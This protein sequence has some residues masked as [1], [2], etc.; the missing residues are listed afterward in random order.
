MSAFVAFRSIFSR[1]RSEYGEILSISLY[2]ARMRKN[3]DQTNPKYGQFFP[4]NSAYPACR[5]GLLVLLRLAY[6]IG[7]LL[8]I[9]TDH[10]SREKRKVLGMI[11]AIEARLFILLDKG[12]EQ[13]A[14]VSNLSQI[15]FCDLLIG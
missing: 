10:D 3:A 1:I 2:L 14:D 4:L 5:K 9:F 13:R 8:G 15:I 11:L 12:K 6:F 7:K